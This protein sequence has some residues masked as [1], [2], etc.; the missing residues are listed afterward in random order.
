MSAGWSTSSAVAALARPVLLGEV[1]VPVAGRRPITSMSKARAR[2]AT[3]L[4]MRP[5]P[6]MPMVLPESSLPV[7]ALPF[8]ALGGVGGG[9]DVLGQRDHQAEGVLG[10]GGVI[11]AGGEEHRD[12]LARWRVTS[13][14][15]E[16]DAVLGDDLEAAAGQRR[17]PCGDGVVAVRRPSKPPLT[18]TS[19]SICGLGQRPAVADDFPAG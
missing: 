9:P 2:L 3:S 5:R 6:M 10:D 1:L 12:L 14:V 18:L 8:A 16:A 13:I 17:S 4:P 19:S 7:I 15:V 11:D